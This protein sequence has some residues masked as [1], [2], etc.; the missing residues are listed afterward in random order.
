MF[1]SYDHL[2]AETG[3]AV[4]LTCVNNLK[5]G[6]LHPVVCIRSG[7]GVVRLTQL[8]FKSCLLFYSNYLLHVS[9]VRPVM[10]ISDVYIST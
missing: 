10:L 1:R 4:G 9:V 5:L 7:S 3:N 6:C 2:E 8:Y